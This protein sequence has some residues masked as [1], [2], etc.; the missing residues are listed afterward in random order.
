M[1]Q[2]Y[3]TTFFS[4]LTLLAGVN[5]AYSQYEDKPRPEKW[6]SLIEGGAFKDRLLP[7]QGDV[8]TSENIWGWEGVKPRYIDNGLEDN[9]WSYWGGNIFKG[10][11]G[12]YH[13]FACGWLE[14]SP[15]GHSEWRNSI[16]FH[17][18][19]D[20]PYGPFVNLGELGK[21]HNPEMY[22]TNS[23]EYVLSVVNGLKYVSKS[24][25]GPWSLEEF[26]YDFRDRKMVKSTNNATFAKREDGSFLYVTRA[27]L[28]F[29]SRDGLGTYNLVN[30]SSVYPPI[31]GRFEDPVIWRD[32][33]Q[34]NL[35]VNDWYGRVAYYSRS[36]NGIDW[37]AED[38]EAY[39]PGV[40]RHADGKVEEWHKFE[41]IHVT[42]DEFGRAY[43]ANFAVCDAEKSK[44]I[45]NDIHSS[46]NIV[47]PLNP[48]VLMSITDK[49]IPSKGG[50]ITLLIRS[51]KGFNAAKDI[52]FASLRLGSHKLVN[53]GNGGCVVNH[54]R[55][56]EGVN[57]TFKASDFGLGNSEE[58]AAKLLGK[59]KNGE[60]IVGYA[61]IPGVTFDDAIPSVRVRSLNGKKLTISVDNFGIK[62]TSGA[63]VELFYIAN[64]NTAP[65]SIAKGSVGA[66]KPYEVATATLNTTFTPKP[67][68]KIIQLRAIT[69]TKEGYTRTENFNYTID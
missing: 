55:C 38:G 31:D 42:Q 62:A 30:D 15:R 47:I 20:R 58:F 69:T 14:S 34:Y 37:V 8:L 48:G 49:E 36:R 18:V 12:K 66:I 26:D 32:D 64:K 67:N 46:K 9:K 17:T 7:M 27:G 11:D 68:A 65:L 56:A 28:I 52:D 51:E 2:H 39:I 41:R 25:D 5:T 13:L 57:V 40:A 1:K 16:V 60:L 63:E 10:D 21:G 19:S 59:R 4:T 29:V 43:Q 33:V 24:L 45:G 23:G 22:R 35:I 54:K 53:Y 44:D 3:L 6:E 50:E 61:R